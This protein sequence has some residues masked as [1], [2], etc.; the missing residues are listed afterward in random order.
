MLRLDIVRVA[1]LVYLNFWRHNDKCIIVIKKYVL[2]VYFVT[3]NICFYITVLDDS[4][5]YLVEGRL[6]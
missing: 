5:P 2:V 3:L 1:M 4:L 6:L